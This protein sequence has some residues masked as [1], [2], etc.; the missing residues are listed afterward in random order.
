MAVVPERQRL[1]NVAVHVD[2]AVAVGAALARDRVGEQ[3]VP[4]HRAGE[5]STTRSCVSWN[6]I[7]APRVIWFGLPSLQSACSSCG[8]FG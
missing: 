7:T 8:V 2:V 4:D 1:G 3:G 5:P 6:I